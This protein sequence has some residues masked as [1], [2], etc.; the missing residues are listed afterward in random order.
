MYAFKT[1]RLFQDKNSTHYHEIYVA[2]QVKNQYCKFL[3]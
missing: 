1:R 2:T 3:V